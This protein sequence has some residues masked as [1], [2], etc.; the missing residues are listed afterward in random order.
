MSRIADPK[1]TGKIDLTKF[2]LRFET[3]DKVLDKVATAFFVSNFSMKKAFEHFDIDG[4]GKISREE[5][6][7]VFASLHLNLKLNEIDEIFKMIA[8]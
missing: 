7:N 1:Q 8:T 2:I 6:R 4:D 3:L 5:F